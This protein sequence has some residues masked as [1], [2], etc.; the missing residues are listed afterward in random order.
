MFEETP[1]LLKDFQRA[2]REVDRVL[3]GPIPMDAACKFTWDTA[4]YV[5]QVARNRA[6]LACDKAGVVIPAR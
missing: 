1:A 4:L 3:Q 6:A 2:Q 5:A